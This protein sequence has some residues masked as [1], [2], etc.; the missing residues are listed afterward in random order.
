MHEDIYSQLPALPKK[1]F[2]RA[3]HWKF[4]KFNGIEIARAKWF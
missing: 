4:I 1:F 3:G 2:I